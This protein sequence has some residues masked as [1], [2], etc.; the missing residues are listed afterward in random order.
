[1]TAAVRA[2]TTLALMATTAALATAVPWAAGGGPRVVAPQD[3]ATP[4]ATTEQIAVFPFSNIT[5]RPVEHW[6]G[7]GISETIATAFEGITGLAVIRGP[8][9]PTSIPSGNGEGAAV[10]AGRRLGARWIVTGAYQRVG[11]RIR[12]TAR[13]TDI[14]TGTVAE[15]ATVDGSLD[16]LFAVQD[17]L[18]ERLRAA[19]TRGSPRTPPAVATSRSETRAPEPAPAPGVTSHPPTG[20]GAAPGALPR[21]APTETEATEATEATGG[22]GFA[23][24]APGVV[25]DGPP[26][27]IAPATITRDADRRAT[28]RAARL[29]EPLRIDGTLDESIYKTM[30]SLS[31]FIQQLPDEGAP[32]TE[33]T[34]AWVFYDDRNV[35][36]GARLWDSA[37]ESQWVANEMQRDS[38]QLLN[39]ETFSV[40]FDTFYD[41]RNGVVFMVNP[42]G[43][44]FDYQITDEGRPN[45]DWNPIWDVT[46]GRFDGGWTVEME[47]PFKSLRFRPGESQVWG[48]QLG[49]SIRWKNEQAYLTPV[50]IS[51]GPGMFRLSAAG[52]LTGVEVPSGN[53]V[54][55]IKP[56][57]IGSL[58][59]DV[60]AVPRISNEGDGDFGLD[61]KYGVTQ[62]LTADFTYNTDFAQV[63]VDEQ[64]VNLTRFSLF[65]PEKREFFLEGRGIFD[66][67]QGVSFVSGRGPGGEGGR[68]GG[69][70]FFGGGDVPTVF[71]SRRIG[72][73][74]GQ[75]VPILGGGRLTG[76]AGDFSIGALNIQTDD[77]LGVDAVAT[78]F[79]VLRV[80]R[81]ILRRSRIGGI[82][83]GRSVSTKGPGSN[84]VYGLDAAFSF[85]DNVNFN[86]YYARSQTPGLVGDE[87]SYQAAFTYNGDLY[88]FQVDHLLVGD[89]FNP[90]IGFLRRNDFRR[91]FTT[92]QYSPRPALR[93]VRQ[94]TFGGSLDY[95]ENGAGQVETRLAQARFRTEFE[96]SDRLS[97]DVQQ[98]HELLEQPFRIASDVTIPIGAYDFRD[99]F[100]SYSLGQ[101]RRLSGTLSLQRGEFFGGDITAVGYRRG[102]IEVTPQ[103]SF[104]PSISINR[105]DL[106][107]G[108]FTATLVTSRVTYTLTPRMFFGGLLQYNSSSDSLSTNLRLR[109]EY[110]PGSELFVVYN[111]Q[112][113]TELRGTPMLENRALVVK[114]TRLFRF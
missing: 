49:R 77:A 59:T 102:R 3:P 100:A 27:P 8:A 56:Y 51:A 86:G 72:L 89:N 21:P 11:D 78:N 60:N 108:R 24:A 57:A 106:P 25:I 53:L 64:Q 17:R 37:P 74:D 16:E 82:F 96:N 9:S 29:D 83:T 31:G 48:L 92:A 54:F 111:D 71:F 84:E 97:L 73:E 110:Q 55:E 101:Q 22:A 30:P 62:N 65:F 23:A 66:F 35:Y 85:Y 5:G 112:R 45:G 91:T 12:L 44:F 43:G 93:A 2:A 69:G 38:F 50:A 47:I 114:F 7:V 95:I 14:E 52:T 34:E 94:F 33:R 20:A 32:A 39:N 28:V 98:S 6:I 63:E 105:I 46:T 13:V 90:E 104:E 19:F 41:R 58:A 103:L 61:V 67:G 88:A 18:V 113:D 10:A 36:V 99:V 1:M 79:T 40:A 81:D 26:A 87:V 68:P 4:G 75:T 15:S 42:I 109:W 70:G 76:K 107:E 80:K